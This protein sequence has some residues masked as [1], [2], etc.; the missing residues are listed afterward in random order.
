MKEIEKV[1]EIKHDKPIQEE[2]SEK[3]VDPES[4]ELST[5]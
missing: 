1:P 2:N 5:Q 4:T 3:E